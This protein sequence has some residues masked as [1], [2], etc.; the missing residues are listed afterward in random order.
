MSNTKTTQDLVRDNSA[1]C[2]VMTAE[3]TPVGDLM[4]FQPAGFPEIGQVS[5]KVKDNDQRVCIVDSAASMANHLETICLAD[6]NGTT[7]HADLEGLP[8]VSC[9]T[10]ENGRARRSAPRLRKATG[11]RR[12]T[13]LDSLDSEREAFPGRA[14]HA[15]EGEEAE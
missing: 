12:I 7:L 3:L 10:K 6:P 9:V 2:L 5:Y 14:T 11:W 8:Y 1:I 15:D 13:L 4:R